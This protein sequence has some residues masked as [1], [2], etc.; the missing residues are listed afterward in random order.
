MTWIRQRK[1]PFSI[2]AWV[3]EKPRVFFWL[4]RRHERPVAAQ[5]FTSYL[6][7][8]EEGMKWDFPPFFHFSPH[9]DNWRLLLLLLP[10]M[11]SSQPIFFGQRLIVTAE[12]RKS[13][14]L[15]PIEKLGLLL[16]PKRLSTINFSL[17]KMG[18]FDSFWGPVLKV[19]EIR[20]ALHTKSQI[21]LSLL[22]PLVR[23]DGRKSFSVYTWP[24]HRSF[25]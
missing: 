15:D 18:H 6:V 21:N 7:R 22:P 8:K 17:L 16:R 4:Q 14:S 12:D 23:H 24:P 11:G 19:H 5:G 3:W 1:K 20:I 9:P 2:D 13:L 25:P 10:F